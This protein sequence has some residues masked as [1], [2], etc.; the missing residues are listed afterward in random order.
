MKLRRYT[1]V[2]TE[3]DV[4]VKK[5]IKDIIDTDWSKDNESQMKVVNL[6]KGIATSDEPASNKFMKKLDAFTS[7]L[8]VENFE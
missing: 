5:I 1:S 7:G 3:A 8:K 2:Y 6:L 4:D